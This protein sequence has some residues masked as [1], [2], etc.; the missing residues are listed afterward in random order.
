[1]GNTPA[2]FF[3]QVKATRQGYTRQSAALKTGV[4]AGDV[5]KMVRC[6]VPT[7]VIAVD[8]P[9]GRAFILSVHGGRRGVISSVPTRHPLDEANR[10][11]LWAEVRDHWRSLR[12]TTRSSRFV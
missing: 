5:R 3:V 9:A 6:P 4:K 12:G 7:Y 8:E 1:M 11:A 2:Y 10:K